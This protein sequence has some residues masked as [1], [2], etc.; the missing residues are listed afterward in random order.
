MNNKRVY[1]LCLASMML[2]I[3]IWTPMSIQAAPPQPQPNLPFQFAQQDEVTFAWED[4][5]KGEAIVQVLNSTTTKRTLSVAISD[6]GFKDVDG[7][8]LDTDKVLKPS[9]ETVTLPAGGT[10]SITFSVE[11][12]VVP[13]AATYS[14]FL[15]VSESTGNTAIHLPITITVSDAGAP[16]ATSLA[17]ESPVPLVDTW[18]VQY[19]RG[20][21]PILGL[22]KL[23]SPRNRFLPL[24]IDANK[25]QTHPS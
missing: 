19:F 12:G 11:D 4:V 14:G 3:F 7:G 9:S 17:G 6:M 16:C 22:D 2:L 10:A 23:C 24:D 21:P 1:L 13:K 8:K 18:T 25:G 15:H 5:K 20:V